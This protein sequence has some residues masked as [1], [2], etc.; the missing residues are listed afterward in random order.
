MQNIR[1]NIEISETRG[2]SRP[3]EHPLRSGGVAPWTPRE[4]GPGTWDQGGLGTWDQGDF[5]PFT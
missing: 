2:V 1:E 5:N 3:S 4:L